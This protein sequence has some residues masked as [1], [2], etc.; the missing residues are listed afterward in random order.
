MTATNAPMTADSPSGVCGFDEMFTMQAAT[1]MTT[2]IRADQASS[3]RRPDSGDFQRFVGSSFMA[4]SSGQEFLAPLAAR[5]W[6]GFRPVGFGFFRR[7]D[8]FGEQLI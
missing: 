3:L 4:G 1:K 8:E 5:R 7:A 2:A 6:S